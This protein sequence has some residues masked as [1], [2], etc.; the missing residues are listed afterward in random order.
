[1]L[2]L[3]M[4]C[5]CVLSCCCAPQA[6]AHRLGRGAERPAGARGLVLLVARGPAARGALPLRRGCVAAGPA[7]RAALP[8]GQAADGAHRPLAL[9]RHAARAERRAQ[10]GERHDRRAQ[11][12]P[13]GLHH[14]LRLR[15]DGLGRHPARA[16]AGRLVGLR[17]RPA[18]GRVHA[19]AGPLLPGAKVRD[20]LQRH[21]DDA[22][23][24]RPAPRHQVSGDPALLRPLW[25]WSR[26]AP[27]ERST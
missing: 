9:G 18:A 15:A 25:M 10:R 4:S 11:L 13:R 19:A 2:P 27:F 7:R 17:I 12:P 5:C 20:G 23:A 1:M 26:Q 22:A 24:R 6:A 14:G 21:D 16:A 3:I 8:L